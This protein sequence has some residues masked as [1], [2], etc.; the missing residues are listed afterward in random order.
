MEQWVS[1]MVSEKRL[2]DFNGIYRLDAE[3]YT[4]CSIL[5]H[6]GTI[7]VMNDEGC[8]ICEFD[9]KKLPTVDTVE[10]VHGRWEL[11]GEADYKCS[12]CGF[13]FTSG[14]PISM[15]PYCRCGAKMDGA[16]NG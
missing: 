7:T 9:A 6:D 4:G 16:E 2:I 1:D 13:R 3:D 10:V 11:M 12:V 8:Y 5:F 15:F 14:D